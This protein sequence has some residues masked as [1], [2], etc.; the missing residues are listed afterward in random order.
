MKSIATVLLTTILTFFIVSCN[1]ADNSKKNIRVSEVKEYKDSVNFAKIQETIDATEKLENIHHGALAGDFPTNQDLVGYGFNSSTLQPTGKVVINDSD[2][3]D[4]S[5]FSSSGQ[6]VTKILE[7]ITSR[8]SLYEKLG[9]DVKAS[10]SYGAYKGSASLQMLNESSINSYSDYLFL[11]VTVIN[12]PLILK[13]SKLTN[14]AKAN[15]HDKNLFKERYGNEFFY[16]KITGGEFV[17]LFEFTSSSSSSKKSVKAGL[18]LAVKTMFAS[19]NLSM[20]MEQLTSKIDERTTTK[21]KFYRLGDEGK[22]AADSVEALIKYANEFPE[23]IK[24]N[25][26]KPV[27]IRLLSKPILYIDNLPS[28]FKATDFLIFNKQ[29]YYLDSLATVVTKIQDINANYNYAI[30]NSNKDYFTTTAIDSA[31]KYLDINKLSIEKMKL[32]YKNCL[33][34]IQDCSTNKDNLVSYIDYVPKSNLS[35]EEITKPEVIN[36]VLKNEEQLIA[37]IPFGVYKTIEFRGQWK[38]NNNNIGDNAKVCGIPSELKIAMVPDREAHENS[39]AVIQ[40]RYPVQSRIMI[41]QKDKTTGQIVDQTLWDGMK[42]FTSKSG[43]KIYVSP[44]YP[45]TQCD[46]PV[47]AYIY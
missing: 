16:G 41:I 12:S 8:S 29:E 27:V 4:T 15:A 40:P 47:T 44:E 35:D 20:A 31:N 42:P 38:M 14:A 39:P 21:V 6:E 7:R 32:T 46:P 36:L 22:L 45:I 13:E 43:V 33:I 11:K 34:S 9:I 26:G 30:D 1:N 23:K 2:L 28:N 19:G 37:E 18:D 17:C 24:N 10:F 25:G 3:Y 5:K